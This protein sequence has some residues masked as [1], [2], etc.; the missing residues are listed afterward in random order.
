MVNSNPAGIS[1]DFASNELET[2]ISE[3]LVAVEELLKQSCKSENPFINEMTTHLVNAGGKRFRP[4]ITL[5]AATLGDISKENVVKAAVVIE[6]THLATL[7]HDDVM[8]EAKLRRGAVSAN[9]RFGNSSAILAGDFLFARA[10]E[11]VADL[12]PAAVRLQAQTFERLVTGQLLETVGPA[13]DIDPVQ[14]HL[15]VLAEKTGSLIATAAQFGAEFAGANKADQVAMRQ[16]GEAIGVAFQLTDDIIDLTS[17][18]ESSGKVP[19]TDLLEGVPTLTTLL[20]QRDNNSE[21]KELIAT[22][23]GQITLNAL[24]QLLTEIRSHRALSQAKEVAIQWAE[25]AKSAIAEVS[26]NATKNA[27]ISICDATITRQS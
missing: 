10:S 27:L 7:Y 15:L 21:D 16:Y 14:H 6:L 3:R 11:L 1:F 19:G 24:P 12:G 23:A 22:L 8:D 5:L 26:N 25:K 4:L 13:K 2:A 20:I 17:D 9:S 18:S